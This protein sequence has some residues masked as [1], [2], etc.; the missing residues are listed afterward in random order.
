MLATEHDDVMLIAPVWL[1][2]WQVPHTYRTEE[3]FP[4]NHDDD[5]IYEDMLENM[6]GLLL[7]RYCCTALVCGTRSTDVHH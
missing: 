1:A 5:A 7:R 4:L 3:V 2:V 6:V